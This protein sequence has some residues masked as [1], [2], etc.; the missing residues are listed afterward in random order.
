MV[1]AQWN[2]TTSYPVNT[3]V[4]YNGLLYQATAYHNTSST[5]A[6]NV[7]MGTI[8]FD[9]FFGSQRAWTLYATPNGYGTSQFVP[10]TS[11]LKNH[12]DPND[13]YTLSGEFAPGIYGNDQGISN[14]YYAGSTNNPT[15]PCPANQ[16]V[17]TINTQGPGGLAYNSTFGIT[18]TLINPV[19][20]SGYT[21]Y[22]NGP[23]NTYP[24][25]NTL[26]VWWEFTA[27]YCFR[28][29]VIF[30]ADVDGTI[31]TRTLTPTDD[32]YTNFT[33]PIEWYTPSNSS[34]TFNFIFSIGYVTFD[35]D[36]ND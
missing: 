4:V 36:P 2:D 1:Y 13:D 19:K 35:I 8:P 25:P 15:T 32:N 23:L 6:P 17:L 14:Q 11:V 3:I 34:V 33:T 30:S 31:N 12:Q 9:T 5:D 10:G 16:C 24:D 7:E 28:R 27:P 29:P 18:K 21:Y 26:H 22:I 20:P